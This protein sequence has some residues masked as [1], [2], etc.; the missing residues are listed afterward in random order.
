KLSAKGERSLARL[1]VTVRTRTMVTDVQADRVTIKC[2]EKS[3][4]LPAHTVLW[5][6]GVQGSPLG[7]LLANAT[8]AQLDRAGRVIVLPDC[9]LPGRPE[10]FVIGDLANFPH[11]TGGQPLPGVA[12]V[13]MQQG[14]YVADL[15]TRRLAGSPPK[16][17]FH[18]HDRG[19]MAT[20]GLHA[21]VA[22]LGWVR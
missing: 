21:A 5:G 16:G 10:V 20:I 7:A 12:P 3:E 1:G 19:S 17:A 6:A 15:I 11:Q 8:G 22:D 4:V 13:A 9:S 14:S 2:G 18:Y